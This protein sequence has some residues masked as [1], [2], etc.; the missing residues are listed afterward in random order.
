[1]LGPYKS[2]DREAGFSSSDRA[3]SPGRYAAAVR[4][5][6]SVVSAALAVVGAALAIAIL[7]AD[8]PLSQR[9]RGLG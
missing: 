7:R 4:V 1:M 8:T 9:E 3:T 5:S 6:T 2:A